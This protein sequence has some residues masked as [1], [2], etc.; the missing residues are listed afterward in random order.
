MPK[1][2]RSDDWGFPRWRPYGAKDRAAA[3]VRLC[4][5]VGCDLPGDRPAP[6]APNSRERWHFCEA[7]AA[8]YN[9][10][11]NYFAGLSAEEA[12]KRAA[13]EERGAS[14]FRKSAHWKWSGPGD[15]SRSRDEM[16]ALDALEL[17]SDADFKSV[18]VAY[19][20]LAKDNHP[21]LKPGDEEAAKR[22]REIQAAY[23]VLKAAEERRAS[24]AS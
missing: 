5:R 3:R 13:E 18:K 10:N 12:A 1:Q 22:F 8:E 2:K 19:R 24:Q 21:D 6:K 16:R 23:D 4:D 15:G 7:H 11:W 14:G 20:R 17:E 9:K